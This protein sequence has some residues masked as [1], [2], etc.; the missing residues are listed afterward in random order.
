LAGHPEKRIVQRGQT[1]RY[2]RLHDWFVP[3]LY[4]TS[5]DVPLLKV[6]EGAGR[7]STDINAGSRVGPAH[8]SEFFGRRSELWD[9]ESQFANEVRRITITGFSGQGKTALA[10]EAGR[11]LTRTRMFK[12]SEFVD[13]SSIE[14]VGEQVRMKEG[15]NFMGKADFTT[16]AIKEELS[17]RSVLLILDNLDALAME[18]LQ[19]LLD[20][21]VSWSE[22]G[23][24]RV[25]CT[26]R[27]PDLYH[28][29]YQ[30]EGM[31]SHGHIRLAGMGGRQR[32]L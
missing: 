15:C 18:P 7:H 25:L 17:E 2:L 8:Y 29:R 20:A 27:R 12:E 16:H 19:K 32:P 31:P 22:A 14:E 5:C 11:W 13:C 21:A 10:K 9:I 23:G 1:R 26:T 4:Q 28:S 30:Q 3:V 6:S 24:S